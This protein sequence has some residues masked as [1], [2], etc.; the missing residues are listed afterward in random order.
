MNYKKIS[1]LDDYDYENEHINIK[2]V[3]VNDPYV[4]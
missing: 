2:I 4:F 1:N 3:D